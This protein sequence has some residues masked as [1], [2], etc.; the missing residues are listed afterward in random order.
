MTWRIISMFYGAFSRQNKVFKC[1]LLFIEITSRKLYAYPLKSKDADS[2]N[3]ALAKFL[4]KINYEIEA[5]NSDNGLEFMNSKFQSF[6]NTYG[7]K[8]FT[9][10]PEN[11]TMNGKVERV[12]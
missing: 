10:E 6:L 9:A 8:H 12:I 7:V 5:L 11:H 4:E 1:I 3:E 2:T